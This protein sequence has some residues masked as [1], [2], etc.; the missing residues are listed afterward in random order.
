MTAN[1]PL[2]LEG[3]GSWTKW[4]ALDAA[5][6]KQLAQYRYLLEEAEEF[7]GPIERV[8]VVDTRDGKA[9]Y[10]LFLWPFGSGVLFHAGTARVAADVVQHSFVVHEPDGVPVAEFRPLR[11]SV[12]AAFQEGRTR[13]GIKEG[14]TFGVTLAEKNPPP[15]ASVAV[16][17]ATSVDERI[18]ELRKD[19][20]EGKPPPD[21]KTMHALVAEAL[22]PLVTPRTEYRPFPVRRLFEL[23]PGQRNALELM[24]DL[25]ATN[26]GFP[27]HGLP[28]G[29]GI[30]PLP[31][32]SAFG[33]WRETANNLLRFLRRGQL[34]PLDELIELDGQ[35]HPAWML[36]SDA[37]YEFRKP[38]E[39]TDLLARSLPPER[40]LAFWEA[41]FTST[42]HNLCERRPATAAEDSKGQSRASIDAQNARLIEILVA[43]NLK[44]AD[45][46]RRRAEELVATLEKTS[47]R[48]DP[49][50]V[51]AGLECLAARGELDPR[52]DELL[53]RAVHVCIFDGLHGWQMV[54][55]FTHLLE[56]LP[57]DRVGPITGIHMPL[58]DRFPSAGAAARLIARLEM[59]INPTWDGPYMEKELRRTFVDSL[60]ELAKPALAE[61]VARAPAHPRSE[62]LADCLARIEKKGAKKPKKAKKP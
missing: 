39:V 48:P 56:K 37:L 26:A 54:G 13:L 30:D 28:E 61:A 7:E 46:G 25:R 42:K 24:A 17:G 41:L 32:F 57:P 55:P 11:E 19:A 5:S 34:L 29:T 53:A 49:F 50:E 14:V 12:G 1:A 36:V 18:A 21:A 4:K 22:G 15:A 33:Y 2:R 38:S 51:I 45:V 16:G 23:T 35:S 40:L 3:Y 44:L 31:V 43:L 6:K 20:A 58:I 47:E 52:H 59:P 60:G 62:L 27:R 8:D 9:V 10:Q